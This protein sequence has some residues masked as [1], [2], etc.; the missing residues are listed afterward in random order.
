MGPGMKLSYVAQRAERLAVSLT[1]L[2]GQPSLL[3]QMSE[4]TEAIRTIPALKDTYRKDLFI[5]PNL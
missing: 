5:R 2:A 3:Q 4:R 1:K